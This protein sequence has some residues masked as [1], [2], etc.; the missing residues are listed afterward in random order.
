MSILEIEGD[1]AVLLGR[2]ADAAE[3]IAAHVDPDGSPYTSFRTPAE[4]YFHV[5]VLSSSLSKENFPN[6]MGPR[7]KDCVTYA[8]ESVD[9]S[10]EHQI[11]ASLRFL[12]TKDPLWSVGH[13][14]KLEIR[15]MGTGSILGPTDR[16]P[17]FPG[18]GSE[19]EGNK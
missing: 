5:R 6:L 9:K 14:L 15:E 19:G 13:E 12:L 1:A 10:E 3:R 4:A 8:V 7:T 11:T 2:I 16:S 17:S 18:P